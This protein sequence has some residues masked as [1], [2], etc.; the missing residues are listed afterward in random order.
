MV[1]EVIH[2][3]GWTW[4]L[5]TDVFLSIPCT[6]GQ[7][8]SK[9]GWLGTTYFSININFVL[10][11]LSGQLSKEYL[12]FFFSYGSHHPFVLSISDT[13][14][15]R[16]ET[17]SMRWGRV[18][19]YN[20]EFGAAGQKMVL[21]CNF[22]S[23]FVL[24]SGFPEPPESLSVPNLLIIQSYIGCHAAVR[25]IFLTWEGTHF[26]NLA[27]CQKLFFQKIVHLTKVA[28]RKEC[29]MDSKCL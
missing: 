20:W 9:Q 21:F 7:N 27:T 2:R 17:F 4:A 23:C 18:M 26:H 6:A 22:S 13:V 3:K 10:F 12:I 29:Q 1:L 8:A 15:C 14:Q 16:Q 5:P 25:M 19:A 11:Y 24:G 28:F